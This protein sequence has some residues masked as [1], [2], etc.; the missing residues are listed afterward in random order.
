M[1]EIFFFFLAFSLLIYFWLCW[2]FIAVLSFISLV[3]C[4][5]LFAVASFVAWRSKGS[6]HIGSVVAAHRLHC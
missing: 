6:R 4:G 1:Q 5:L 2:V 3:V